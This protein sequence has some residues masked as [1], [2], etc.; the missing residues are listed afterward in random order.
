MATS[1]YFDF[2]RLTPAER[3]QL[4]QDLWDSV[5]STSG[6][7]VLGLTDEQRAEL[8]YRL[9]DLDAAPDDQTPWEGLKDHLLD[10][11]QEKKRRRRGA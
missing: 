3:L 5:E 9:E 6:T 8:D 11:L 7:D 1:P 10:E 2:S 4:A